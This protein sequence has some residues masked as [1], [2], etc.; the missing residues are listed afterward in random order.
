MDKRIENKTH[1]SIGIYLFQE[2]YNSFR[3]EYLYQNRL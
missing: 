1:K 3:D 2:I